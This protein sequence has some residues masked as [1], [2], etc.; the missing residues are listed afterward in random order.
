MATRANSTTTLLGKT[1]S[2]LPTGLAFDLWNLE[3]RGEADKAQA[4]L[5]AHNRARTA[6]GG[7]EYDPAADFTTLPFEGGFVFRARA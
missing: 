5:D 7:T 6:F 4:L 3:Q 1:Y 2:G